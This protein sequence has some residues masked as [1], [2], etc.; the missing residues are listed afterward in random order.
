MSN[1]LTASMS[2]SP[3]RAITANF[4]GSSGG[5][6]TAS[7]GGSSDG[8]TAAVMGNSTGA[9]GASMG[10]NPEAMTAKFAEGG[11][12][13]RLVDV[14]LLAASWLGDTG[15]YSQVVDIAG[16]T[17]YSKVDLQPSVEQLDIFHEKDIAFTTEN[18]DGVVTVYVVGDRPTN[19]Y[20]IQATVMEV[21]V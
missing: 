9:M 20:T 16:I 1:T 12:A 8:T 7:F 19:D 21:D 6:L 18:V 11:V 4:G 10:N 13:V 15:K 3:K 17:K 14:Q 5:A 2:G